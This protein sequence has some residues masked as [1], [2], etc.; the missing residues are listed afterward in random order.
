LLAALIRP[1]FNQPNRE[2]AGARLRE[3][4]AQLERPLPKVARIL[5]QAVDE[6]LAFYAVPTEHWR[7][8]R[9]T[10]PLER[11]NREIGERTDVAASS[12]TT[13]R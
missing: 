5:E 7:K 9:S 10:N 12:P 11:F 1:S 2:E 4:V 13:A 6:I 3:A 8:L